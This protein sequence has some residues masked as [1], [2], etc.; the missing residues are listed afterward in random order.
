MKHLVLAG[1]GHAHLETLQNIRSFLNDGIRVSVVSPAEY[2]YYSGMGPGMLGGFYAPDRIRFAVKKQVEKQ[3]GHFLLDNVI[4]LNPQK[5]ILFLQ[6][7]EVLQYDLLS[8]NTGSSIHLPVIRKSLHVYPVKP[9]EGLTRAKI[10]IESLAG[11]QAITV[12]VVGGGPAGVEIA[13]NV[14]HLLAS[15]KYPYQIHLY[16]G[17]MLLAGFSSFVQK[18]TRKILERKGVYIVEGSHLLSIEEN[19]LHFD[20]TTQQHA[21]CTILC[22]GVHPD[23]FFREAGLPTGDDGGFF[24]NSALQCIEYPEIFGGGDC[25]SFAPCTL[26]KVG[27][28]AVRENPVLLYNLRAY[29]NK[30]KLKDF[31]P[32]G[33]YLLIFNLGN[34]DGLLKKK[35]IQFSG[36]FAFRIKDYIDCKFMDRFK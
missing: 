22:T 18:Q 14:A 30:E 29:L 35:W 15:T 23:S 21:D 34:C 19:T 4:G 7:G 17:R 27:V 24:V 26:A 13:G 32:G 31:D 25:I 3:G 9:I 6:S 2:H 33:D 8:F 5:K 20:D 1:A 16:A 36:T 12:A 11:K 28:Y 10:A